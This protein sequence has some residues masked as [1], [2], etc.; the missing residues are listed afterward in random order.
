MSQSLWK[1]LK[2]LK[3][4]IIKL[5]PPGPLSYSDIY[6]FGFEQ[7]PVLSAVWETDTDTVKTL[8]CPT[9]SPHMYAQYS[10][11]MLQLFGLTWE[12]F[13]QLLGCTAHVC[14][15]N[16]L[17]W[18]VLSWVSR[19]GFPASSIFMKLNSHTARLT[20]PDS[21]SSNR[22]L[23][24]G[25]K[26]GLSADTETM[27]WISVW[28]HALMS[29]REFLLSVEKV[30]NLQRFFFAPP[31]PSVSWLCV[32]SAVVFKN[33]E[34]RLPISRNWKTSNVMDY[35]PLSTE[36]TAACFRINKRLYCRP[37]TS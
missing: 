30:E 3:K 28:A 7:L 15:V 21:T 6:C 16:S 12:F 5:V 31:F 1:E 35:Y 20:W 32:S 37:T 13:R 14:A 2:L 26:T 27:V 8:N 10:H 34:V 33:L 23:S 24:T 17:T 36:D 25:D 11:G 22:F 4:E 9:D 18:A 19:A 29:A